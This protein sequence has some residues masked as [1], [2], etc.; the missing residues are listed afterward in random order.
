MS[1]KESILETIKEYT[2][3]EYK[4]S[5][6]TSDKFK[7]MKVIKQKIGE[8]AFKGDIKLINFCIQKELSA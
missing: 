7:I 2:S 6:G 3:G 5:N 1:S 4:F 8:D